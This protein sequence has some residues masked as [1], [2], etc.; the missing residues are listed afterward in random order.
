MSG[1]PVYPPGAIVLVP[2]MRLKCQQKWW[3]DRNGLPGAPPPARIRRQLEAQGYSRDRA[4]VQHVTEG[5]YCELDGT[6]RSRQSRRPWVQE[7]LPW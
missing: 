3:A 1:A 5:P 6:R 7:E 4:F 2:L